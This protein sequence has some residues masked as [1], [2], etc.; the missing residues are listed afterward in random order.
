MHSVPVP[1]NVR[2]SSNSDIIVRRSRF[3]ND[4]NREAQLFFSRAIDLDPTFSRSYAGLSFTHFQN[5]FLL[6]ENDAEAK[7]HLSALA[8]QLKR[9]GWSEDRNRRPHRFPRVS[10]RHGVTLSV[11]LCFIPVTLRSRRPPVCI[12]LLT[13]LSNWSDYQLSMVTEAAALLPPA[14]R[15][16]FLRS[17]ASV[18]GGRER[19][20]DGALTRALCFVLAER[21]VAVGRQFFLDGHRRAHH[22]EPQHRRRPARPSATAEGRG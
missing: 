11:R 4:G 6:A 19:P 16:G 15:D 8:Q 1:I 22:G 10:Q 3:T 13:R 2:C 9:L 14:T 12:K 7:S 5:A 17:V 20:S 18:L 21:G